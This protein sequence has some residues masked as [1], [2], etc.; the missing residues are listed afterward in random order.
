LDFSFWKR[1]AV[2]LCFPGIQVKFVFDASQVPQGAFLAVWGMTPVPTQLA[3]EF[4]VARLEDGFLRSVGLGADLIQP[5]SWVVD[6]QGIYY[7]AT[8]PSDLE[9]LLA[10]SV[11]AAPLL[12]R[13]ALLRERIVSAGLTKYNVGSTRWQRPLR[14]E[15]VILVPGQV[16]SDNSLK[17][18]APGLRT[19]INLLKAVRQSNPDAYIVYKPHPDVVARLRAGG[20]GED[21]ARGWCDEWVSDVSMPDLL[22]ETDEVH[23]LTS[24]AGFE[25]LMRGKAVT[26]YGQPFYSGWGLTADIVP[27]RRRGRRLTLDELVAGALIEYPL[28]FSRKGDRLVSPEQA[29]DE[30]IAWRAREGVTVPWWRELCR[31]ALRRIVGVR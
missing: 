17:Y 19:N 1:R 18:G 5:L 24:L 2:R 15:K 7:D 14:A 28:Y 16:E 6:R 31:I 22:R 11:F 3:G 29:I 30:L 8:R 20:A 23:V 26:C 10:S 12:E 4:T 25:A 13:A 9:H 27:Q 21:T